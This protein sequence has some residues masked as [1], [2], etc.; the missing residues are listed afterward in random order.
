[1]RHIS[2][3]QQVVCVCV[4]VCVTFL[5]NSR[6]CVRV[7]VTFLQNSRWCVRVCAC[8]TFLQNSRWCV[9]V[10]VC[11]RVWHFCRTAGGVCVRACMNACVHACMCDI[12]AEQVVR[13][14]VCVW[15]FCK[16]AG[17]VCVCA[18][19]CACRWVCAC[20]YVCMSVRLRRGERF[21]QC[22]QECVLCFH[23]FHYCILSVTGS[24]SCCALLTSV[25]LQAN[26]AYAR[27]M[28]TRKISEGLTLLDQHGE[29][30]SRILL[31]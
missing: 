6:W 7:C 9:C 19:V 28:F 12:S 27:R 30:Q 10:C 26:G 11:V 31:L 23:N 5:Q 25:L 1:M 13:A 18:C 29:W 24:C 21:V 3:K 8:V 14:C 20:V 17:V 16:T 4:R 22:T 15:H 2:A